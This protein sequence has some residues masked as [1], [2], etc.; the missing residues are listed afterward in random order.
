[1]YLVPSSIPRPYLV[2]DGACGYLVP[3]SPLV[4][5]DEVRGATVRPASTTNLVLV[6]QE[7]R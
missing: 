4:Y 3:S 1:M 6:H 5:R 7:S 2:R